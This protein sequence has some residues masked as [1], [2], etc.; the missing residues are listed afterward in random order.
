MTLQ[1]LH[2]QFPY[3]W[4]KFVFLFYQCSVL[5]SYSA[6]GL[7]SATSFKD[8]Q[9][10]FPSSQGE[11]PPATGNK[12]LYFPFLLYSAGERHFLLNFLQWKSI[13]FPLLISK[14]ICYF[15]YV[16]FFAYL[17]FFLFSIIHLSRINLIEK[18][19]SHFSALCLRGTVYGIITIFT[20][21]FTEPSIKHTI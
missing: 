1:L 12:V 16:I 14:V 9:R 8:G 4:G 19:V 21:F 5:A 7:I 18:I 2:S 13:I 10:G 20:L 6:S 11:K 17:L 3:I 15:F